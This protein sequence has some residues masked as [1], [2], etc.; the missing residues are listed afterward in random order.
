MPYGVA[1]SVEVRPGSSCLHCGLVLT[2]AAGVVDH[3]EAGVPSVP[4]PGDFTVCIGCGHVMAFDERLNL[5]EL[6]ASEIRS[7]D[8]DDRIMLLKAAQK[9]LERDQKRLLKR[10]NPK[11]DDA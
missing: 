1:P 2:G 11:G 3:K 4:S 9:R 8:A 5:R 10:D 6:S 7:M